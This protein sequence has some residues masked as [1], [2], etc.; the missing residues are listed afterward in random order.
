[1]KESQLCTLSPDVR[2]YLQGHNT[3]NA[4]LHPSTPILSFTPDGSGSLGFQS[5]KYLSQCLLLEIL[6]LDP[7]G[8]NLP[9][10][11]PVGSLLVLTTM[12][13][14]EV[15]PEHNLI[16]EKNVSVLRSTEEEMN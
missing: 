15:K 10:L 3:T 2:T 8:C 9:T 12:K 13:Y 7:S 16:G 14:P 4:E 1:M 6:P 11:A 5:E